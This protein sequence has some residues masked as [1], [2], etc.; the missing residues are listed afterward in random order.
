[1]T[2]HKN[3]SYLFI[4][5]HIKEQSKKNYLGRLGTTFQTS[6]HF[7]YYDM[8]T[9]KIAQVDKVM[10]SILKVILEQHSFNKIMNLAFP[11]EKI[12]HSLKELEYYIKTQNILSPIPLTGLS[13]VDDQN[14]NKILNNE[15]KSVILETTER[16]NL[17]CKYCIYHPKHPEY[18]GFG[19]KDMPFEVARKSINYLLSHS[20]NSN[21]V[22]IGFYGGEPLL[23]F[24]LIIKVVNYIKSKNLD[25]D[26]RFS[27]TTNGTLIT[28]SIAKFLVDNKFNLV[29]SLDGPKDIHDENRI[30]EN[31][32]GSFEKTKQGIINLNNAYISAQLEPEYSLS[33]VLSGENSV[34]KYDE[35]QSFIEE[36]DWLPK[37]ISILA[38]GEDT[39]PQ[40]T[41]PIKPQCK[42]EV[43]LYSTHESF[44]T[45]WSRINNNK[46]L[47]VDASIDQGLHRIHDRFITEIPT[48][49]YGM[50]G[51]CIPGERK[52]YV[53]TEGTFL[54]CEKVGTAPNIGNIHTGLDQNQIKKYFISN[55]S[56]N[57]SIYCKDCWASNLCSLCY[58]DSF[59]NTGIN[60]TLRHKS[61][62]NERIE[63]KSLLTTY[64]ELLEK[65]PERIKELNNKSYF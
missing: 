18:R 6:N 64:H 38:S 14:L 16:C 50:N 37:N 47:F 31:G 61:C 23:N 60:L 13:L 27:M 56:K 20:K 1:M 10:F 40:E 35:I 52:F 53:N 49:Y 8:G 59:D 39:G 4:E 9:G 25:R 42:D 26:I 55:F 46:P 15:L 65:S 7:Y 34:S 58:I 51:C 54:L 33:M 32:K 36:T 57:A 5:N 48:K 12:L 17:R 62:I 28:T 30:F 3:S 45:Y 29:I 24:D 19:K 2:Y 43:D 44:I 63:L 41:K 11:K 22:Y 21:I